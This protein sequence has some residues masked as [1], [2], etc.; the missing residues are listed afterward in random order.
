MRQVLPVKSFPTSILNL[1]YQNTVRFRNWGK[2]RHPFPSFLS[3]PFFFLNCL[4][5]CLPQILR[6]P[7]V[8]QLVHNES[9]SIWKHTLVIQSRYHH[10]IYVKGLIKT[11]KVISQD[12]RCPGWNSNERILNASS[13][14]YN[15][16]NL[17]ADVS[18]C[19][20]IS[21]RARGLKQWLF[22]LLLKR[23]SIRFLDVLQLSK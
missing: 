12:W 3:I 20:Y 8:R 11:T 13:E 19:K 18:S 4:R 22:W 7:V 17:L 10:R 14:N 15:Y 9:E 5:W 23:W 21:Y 1:V 16:A 2:Q 6:F